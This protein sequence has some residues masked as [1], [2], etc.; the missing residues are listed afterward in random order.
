VLEIAVPESGFDDL[1]SGIADQWPS[2]L[3]YGTSFLTIG[4]LWLAHHALFRRTAYADAVIVRLNLVLL[5]VVAFLPFPTSLV[6]EA[7]NRTSAERT[8]VLFYGATLFLVSLLFTA[9]GRY[10]VVNGGLLEE[11][12][13]SDVQELVR[14]LAPSLGF[15]VAILLLALL[16]PRV[17]ALGFL[18]VAVNAVVRA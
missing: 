17:A 3:A 1:W 12:A 15:Y 7:F 11:G 5:M 16:A 2:Y 14:R 10:I 13:R 8:A 9:M 6:A 18:V 4:A